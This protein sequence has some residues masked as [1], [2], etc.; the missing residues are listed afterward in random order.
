MGS[1]IAAPW[2]FKMVRFSPSSIAK[3]CRLW[4]LL[5][6]VLPLHPLLCQRRA[7]NLPDWMAQLLYVRRDL[8]L[9]GRWEP[10]IGPAPGPPGCKEDTTLKT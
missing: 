3:N 5:A 7:L 2:G 1:S 9:L 4:C 6:D 10:V 8:S